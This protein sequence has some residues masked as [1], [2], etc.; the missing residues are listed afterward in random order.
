MDSFAHQVAKR[1]I[2]KALPFDA[3]FTGENGAFDCQA[4]MTLAGGIVASVAAVLL[5]VV[6]ELD[7]R[8]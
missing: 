3:A 5:A 1:G 8:G 7:A 6:D 2:D 4:E